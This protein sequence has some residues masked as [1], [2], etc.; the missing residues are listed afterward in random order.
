MA[1]EPSGEKLEVCGWC[2]H[3]L[4]R[5]AEAEGNVNDKCACSNHKCPIFYCNMTIDEW[6]RRAAPG[7]AVEGWVS[8]NAIADF[9]RH[10]TASCEY[11]AITRE[12][13]GCDIPVTVT[14][15]RV[16]E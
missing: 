12:N 9:N 4:R 2:G 7:D 13:R 11:L 8:R 5:F 6:N 16:E 1:N 3:V 14:R 15:R 10:P